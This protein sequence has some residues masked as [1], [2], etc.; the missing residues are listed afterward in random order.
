MRYHLLSL[1]LFHFFFSA[2]FAEH[3]N[4]LKVHFLDYVNL[5]VIVERFVNASM[6]QVIVC[7]S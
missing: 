4:L 2:S 3:V 7:L 1:H 6:C 5:V